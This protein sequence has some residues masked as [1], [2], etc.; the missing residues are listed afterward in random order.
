VIGQPGIRCMDNLPSL[1]VTAF[2]YQFILNATS[3]YG[4]ILPAGTLDESGV[5]SDFFGNTS[6]GVHVRKAFSYAI[7]YEAYLATL[8]PYAGSSA[9][10]P[11]TVILPVLP[12]YSPSVSGYYFDL[13]K[14]VEELQQVPGLWDTGFTI[15]FPYNVGS[16]PDRQEPYEQMSQAIN[17]LNPKFHCSALGLDWQSYMAAINSKWLPAYKVGWLADY[18]DPHDFA[19]PYYYSSGAYAKRQGYSNPTMDTLIDQGISQSDYDER[20]AAYA[21]VQQLVIDDC[22][23]TALLTT[24]NR[25]FERTWVCGWYY[26]PAYPGVYAANLWKWYYTPQAQLDIVNG[27]MTNLLPYDVNYDGKVNMYDIGAAAASFGAI[28][29]PPTSPRWI[30]RCDFNN[31]HKIDMK[32]I[33]GVAKNFGKTS[34]AWTPSS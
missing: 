19:Y 29:G 31:D 26:N 27:T 12:H 15:K 33:G 17:S 2:L 16:L 32:D 9:S 11:P 25:H 13:D 10:H 23:S 6:W 3:P 18:P 34:S 7:D 4:P 24:S 20:E 8:S 14:T 22:P 1:S 28:Y 21:G 5:P 30:Y